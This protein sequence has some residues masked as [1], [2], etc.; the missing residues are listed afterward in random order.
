MI[1]F[2]YPVVPQGQARIRMQVSAAHTDEQID[3]AIA[4]FTEVGKELG[5]HQ[6]E[7]FT[8][9]PR[10]PAAA[11]PRTGRPGRVPRRADP[12]ARCWQVEAIRHLHE[13]MPHLHVANPRRGQTRRGEFEYAAQVDWET[14]H[15][16]RAAADGVILFWLAKEETHFCERAY[17]Q[18]T[19]FELAEWKMRH[20]RDGAK[21]VIGL[22]DG[23]T[24]AK[25]IRHRFGQ[26]CPSVP[27]CDS[28]L[29]D[30]RGGCSVAGVRDTTPLR[31]STRPAHRRIVHLECAPNS[32]L[33]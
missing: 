3:R 4:A 16:R 33:P 24:G 25:Y 18:T 30:V 29:R 32:E 26:D 1:G 14:H 20:E 5:S 9:V 15:L 27:V 8:H 28:L 7:V 19:R 21:L 6:V 17:A 13:M 2:S 10:H 23:F 31:D 22:D 12:G 11:V